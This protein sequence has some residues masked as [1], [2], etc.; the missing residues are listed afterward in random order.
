M[1]H[2]FADYAGARDR[3]DELLADERRPRAHWARLYEEIGALSPAALRTR[4]DLVAREIR[5]SGI[6]YNVY[7][8]PQGFDRPWDLDCLPLILPGDEWAQIERGIAQRAHLLDRILADLYGAASLHARGLLPAAIVKGHSGY[9]RPACG[10]QVPGGVYLHHYAADLARSP[11]GRWWVL[12][13]RTQAPSGAAYALENRLMVA[14]MFPELFRDLGVRR[15][16]AYF[17]ALRDALHHHAP[18]DDGPP[19]VV[20][21]TPG[22]FNETYFEHSFLSRY[23][24][25]PLVEGGDLVVR[26][27]CVWLK[28]IE[29]LRRVHAILRRQ[30]DAYCD[31]LE[32]RADSA[33]GIPG[34]A[35]CARRG[36]VLLANALGAG[37]LE[38]GALLG[39]L[40]RI[41][42]ALLGEELKLPSV[43]TWWCGEP[44]ALADALTKIARLVF[45][46]ADPGDGFEPVFGQDLKGDALRAFRDRLVAAPHRFVAQELVRISQAPSFAQGPRVGMRGVGLRVFAVATPDGYRVMPGGLTRVSTHD[47]PRVISSQRGGSSKDTWV[48]GG[49]EP[50]PLA[51]LLN[52]PQAKGTS[53]VSS[54]VVEH[55][56]WFGRYAERCDDTARLLRVA[57]NGLV[58]DLEPTTRI[59]ALLA[60]KAGMHGPVATSTRAWCAAATLD[61][62]P[63]GLPAQLRQLARVAFSLRERMSLDNWR[64]INR[65]LQDPAV[66]R[67]LS[68]AE[69]LE[70]LDRAIL[71]LMTVAGFTLDGMTR[72]LGWRFLSIGRRLERLAFTCTALETGCIAAPTEHLA[73]LLELCDSIVTYRA[74]Y[75][76]RTGWPEVLELL[77]FD[78]ANP[79]SVMFQVYGLHDTLQKLAAATD[80]PDAGRFTALLEAL[81]ALAPTAVDPADPALAHLLGELRGAAFE[82]ND[83][84]TARYFSHLGMT[85]RSTLAS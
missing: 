3:Y 46:P 51:T 20:I 16:A 30:D 39:Y 22:P 11:D 18:G 2:L 48:L 42:R 80:Y 43:A 33:L 10:M 37:V 84:L 53:I 57:L 82:L 76:M 71:A 4:L 38:S 23:L 41:C 55:L 79:R 66:G 6:T 62:D 61:R 70:W 52:R 68:V 1:Q 13:D 9:L 64:T 19:L 73:W 65:L 60:D 50:G 74:R 5:D 7:A 47:D 59:L 26:D 32:L 44:A 85:G 27:D 15:L 75:T 78:A 56:F 17:S 54:R 63:A 12:G 24:G 45:K 77:V 69:T 36:R 81:R 67:T 35:E 31:P 40:P 49:R 8:D 83:G 72:D 34:L 25:F 21:L 28:T 58:Q 14:R 29:G